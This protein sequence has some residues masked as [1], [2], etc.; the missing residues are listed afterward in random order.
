MRALFPQVKPTTQH[1]TPTRERKEQAMSW[2]ANA[3]HVN[4]FETGTRMSH[5]TGLVLRTYEFINPCGFCFLG[6]EDF[7]V[8]MWAT[9]ATQCSPAEDPAPSDVE[10]TGGCYSR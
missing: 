4:K 2:T 3:H 7:A 9:A 8:H 10:H 1:L 6:Q 5:G